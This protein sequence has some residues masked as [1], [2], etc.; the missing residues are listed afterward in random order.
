[1]EKIPSS[2]LTFPMNDVQVPENKISCAN[3]AMGLLT[4]PGDIASPR[5]KYLD[6]LVDNKGKICNLLFLCGIIW[7]GCLAD[8]NLNHATY[9]SENALLPGNY[10]WWR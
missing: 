1:M 3:R 7:F 9:F 5:A 10:R 2:L 4:N 6:T 8:L